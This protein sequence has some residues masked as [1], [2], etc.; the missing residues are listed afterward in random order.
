MYAGIRL[1]CLRQPVLDG[2]SRVPQAQ[3]SQV[4]GYSDSGSP[5][6]RSRS[7]MSD[8]GGLQRIRSDE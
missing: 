4:E 7:N 2:Q 6:I 5:L 3:V 8:K 1:S